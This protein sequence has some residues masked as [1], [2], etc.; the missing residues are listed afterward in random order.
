VRGLRYAVRIRGDAS[1][2]I[3]LKKLYL[4]SKG[5]VVVAGWL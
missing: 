5:F 3:L 1:V 4:D 2:H